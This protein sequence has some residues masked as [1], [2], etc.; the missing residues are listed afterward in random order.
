MKLICLS[1]MLKVFFIVNLFFCALFTVT[2]AYGVEV[3]DLYVAKVPVSS[4]S[5]NERISALKQAMRFVLVKVG[6]QESVHQSS[7]NARKVFNKALKNY[8]SYMAQYRYE[9]AGDQILLVAT[10]DEAKINDLFSQ[11]NLPLWGRL[12]PLILLW[13]VDE[14]GL[15]R[16]VLSDSSVSQLP[17]IAKQFSNYRGLPLMMPLMDLTDL[18]Q[19]N[20]AEL[21]GRFPQSVK[22]ASQRYLAE[23]IVIIRISN[24]SLLPELAEPENCQPL[25]AQ[26]NYVLDW[27]LISPSRQSQAQQKSQQYSELYQGQNRQNL[28]EQ[29]LADITQVIYQEYALSTTTQNEFLIDVA[30][31][32]S[33]TTYLNVSSFLE[34][35]SSVQSVKLISAKGSNW[36]FDLKLIGSQRSLLA[37][38]QLS[39]Q[40]RQYIDPLAAVELDAVPV[41]YWGNK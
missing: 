25:C 27:T 41:F 36:R 4:Q 34:Q 39:K 35:L 19:I 20:T 22:Q 12:R 16:N 23:A 6:G 15:S 31:I 33:L 17:A 1:Q 5:G 8:K 21:W 40:L 13:V 14:H 38:L 24:S 29:A 28:I 2:S 11:A 18:T 9:R 7:V 37:S 32:D 10:F 30:N 26:N 3:T